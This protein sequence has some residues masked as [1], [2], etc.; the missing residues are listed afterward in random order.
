M[1]SAQ[2]HSSRDRGAVVAADESKGE[3]VDVDVLVIPGTPG[4]VAA[5]GLVANLEVGGAGHRDR[6]RP[7]HEPEDRVDDVY[8]D[9]DERA[10]AIEGLG[11]EGALGAGR[12]AAATV[13]S[14]PDEVDVAQVAALDDPLEGD[15][16]G[17]KRV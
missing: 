4:V 9:V 13:P 1:F 5:V 12:K 10:A 15:G 2:L 11:V 7:A 3:V 17:M 14:G 16:L 8:A 6:L